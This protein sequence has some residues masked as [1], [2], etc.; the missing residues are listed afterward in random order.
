MH[1][2]FDN[3]YDVSDKR[4]DG[5]GNPYGVVKLAPD[6]V[7]LQKYD[8]VVELAMPRTPGNRDLGNF[9]VEAT[10]YAPGSIIDPVKDTLLPGAAAADNRLARS[11][12]PAILPYRS[13]VVEYLHRL[14]QLHL[15]ILGWRDET[16]K[17]R[18]SMWEGLEFV[19][20]L[21][22]VP[23]TMRLEIQSTQRMQIYSTKAHFRARFTGL[24]W[25][26]YNH[27]MFSAAI[28]VTSFWTTEMLFTGLAWAAISLYLQSP[29]PEPKAEPPEDRAERIKQEE[30]EKT[31][32]PELSDTER[33]FPTASN[34][35]PLRYE[36]PRVKQEQD[37]DSFVMPEATN[38]ATEADDEDEDADVFLDSGIGTSLESSVSRRDSIR[39]RRGRAR[40]GDND[41]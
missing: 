15:Y 35:Q 37:E 30:D 6:L 12:R 2:Q 26:M 39:K 13:V 31:F 1:L 29:H 5:A 33:T 40:S 10:M 21:R 16:D 27:R 28:F 23:A 38:R 8:V 18:I 14:T 7:S 41:R 17:L 32:N 3:V 9:M 34:Q 24:R 36:S 20:G 25:L 19:R 4:Y 22:N 11:R